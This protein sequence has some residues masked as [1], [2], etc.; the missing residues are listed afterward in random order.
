MRP[1]TFLGKEINTLGQ[2]HAVIRSK[3][4]GTEVIPGD[5][6]KIRETGAQN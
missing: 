5:R 3:V 4:R 2:R 1:R 6:E